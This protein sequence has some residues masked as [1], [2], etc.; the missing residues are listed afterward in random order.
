M[1]MERQCATCGRVK[2]IESYP[3]NNRLVSGYD[4]TCKICRNANQRIYRQNRKNNDKT[5][6]EMKLSGLS[7]R[8]W[9]AT[10]EFLKS[11]GYDVTKDIHLQFSER[12][13]LPYKKRPQRNT[14]TYTHQDC[15]DCS[16]QTNLL[17]N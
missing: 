14:L 11:I 12:H 5:S 1:V 15:L 4:R 2:K 3:K 8:D 16:N 10:Y 9:C 6:T 17:S 13:G 7:R